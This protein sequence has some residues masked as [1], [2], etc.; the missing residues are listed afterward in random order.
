[1]KKLFQNTDTDRISIF[2]KSKTTWRTLIFALFMHLSFLTNGQDTTLTLYEA[3]SIAQQRSILHVKS[4]QDVVNTGNQLEILNADFKPQ[5]SLNANL[6]NFYKSSSAVIQPD[7]TI[8]FQPISQDNS[9]VN[10]QLTQ[11]LLPTNTTIFAE[12]NLQRY[13]DFAGDFSRYNAI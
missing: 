3:I 12:A 1:M 2:R 11:K 6:P 7:G 10:L 13:Q 9:L 5:L 8:N 4:S